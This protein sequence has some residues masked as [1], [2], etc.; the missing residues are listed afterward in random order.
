MFTRMSLAP[1]QSRLHSASLTALSSPVAEGHWGRLRLIRMMCTLKHILWNFIL[2]YIYIYI[3]KN[4]IEK[5]A[6]ERHDLP[7][8]GSLPRCSK[9]PVLSQAKGRSRELHESSIWWEGPSL[10]GHKLLFYAS[11]AGRDSRTTP[12]CWLQFPYLHA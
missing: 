1:W 2:K 11:A 9:Q 7:A 3:W 6:R 12:S 4:R 8:A 10:S 5:G